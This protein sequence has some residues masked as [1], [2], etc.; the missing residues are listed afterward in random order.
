M[1][2]LIVLISIC[3]LG[4]LTLSGQEQDSLNTDDTIF[5]FEP[6]PSYPGGSAA[7]NNFIKT[8]L[9]YPRHSKNIKGKVFIGFIVNEDG[10]LTDFEI[11]RGLA[12]PFNNSALGVLKRMPNWIPA[13][14]DNKPLRV[15]MVIPI[16]FDR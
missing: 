16:T 8:H 12:E 5:V 10:S 9:K 13:K 1:R 6:Q 11:V 2:Q 3:L 4:T 15:K 14:R 7:L